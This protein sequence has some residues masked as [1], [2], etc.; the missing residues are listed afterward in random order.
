MANKEKGE[1]EFEVDGYQYTVRYD[2]NSFCELEDLFDQPVHEILERFQSKGKGFGFRELRKFMYAG[3]KESS[4]DITLR[5]A[6]ELVGSLGGFS[7]AE[8]YVV[9]ALALAFPESSGDSKKKQKRGSGA[10]S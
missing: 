8:K 7:E 2:F 4:P 6:G 5:G 10:N 3:I 1:V 9:N